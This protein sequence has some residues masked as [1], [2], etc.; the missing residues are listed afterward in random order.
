MA[1]VDMRAGAVARRPAAGGRCLRV[2]GGPRAARGA[3]AVAVL[4]WGSAFSA[5]A[6]GK[7]ACCEPPSGTCPPAACGSVSPLRMPWR[8]DGALLAI[9]HKCGPLRGAS[10][11]RLRTSL[12][13]QVRYFWYQYIHSML[14]QVRHPLTSEYNLYEVVPFSA[15]MEVVVPVMNQHGVC[16]H[17]PLKGLS[18][19]MYQWAATRIIAAQ[20]A[21]EQVPFPLRTSSNAP[22]VPLGEKDLPY[23][24]A[25]DVLFYNP[26][27]EHG[28]EQPLYVWGR[29]YR[30]YTFVAR[31]PADVLDKRVL[32]YQSG[33][34]YYN[35]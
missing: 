30:W 32:S 34:Y 21:A 33:E 20:C 16:M 23:I 24:C 13:L 1:V 11:H 17:L 31:D 5:R 14:V 9:A 15:S 29:P 8:R 28:E 27:E 35:R 18:V 22:I 4:F 25:G 6:V 12:L 10:N 3:Q 7:R 2:G 19:R 26:R